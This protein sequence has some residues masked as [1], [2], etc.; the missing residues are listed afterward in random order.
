MLRM[1][2]QYQTFNTVIELYVDFEEV[3][4]Q[5][6]PSSYS[7]NQHYDKFIPNSYL[8]SIIIFCFTNFYF[9]INMYYYYYFP[10]IL[11]III[12]IY[13]ICFILVF[14]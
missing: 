2:H 5:V 4:A 1:Y 9:K 8:V 7:I 11:I 10:F 6:G 14:C 3:V 12:I 13:K